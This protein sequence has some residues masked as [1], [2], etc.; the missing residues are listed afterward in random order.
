MRRI[1]VFTMLLA[2]AL[3]GAAWALRTA[4][5]D[6]T[7]SIRNGDG[8]LTVDMVR[9]AAIGKI[10][11]GQLRVDVLD[12]TECVTLPVFGA[13]GEWTG[14]RETRLG[15]VPV[16]VFSGRDIRFRLVGE[17][18]HFTIG[19]LRSPAFGFSLSMVARARGFIRGFGGVADGTFSRNGDEYVS[20]PD[21]GLRFF[22]G[23]APATSSQ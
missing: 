17:D 12:E 2:L 19:T 1:V 9:G 13:E 4:P 7:L 10:V 5:G 21:A 23:Q 6:G 3:P 20:L 14:T 11:Q 22:L 18:M 8:Q 15:E 16:C